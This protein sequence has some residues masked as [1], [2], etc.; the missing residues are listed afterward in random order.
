MTKKSPE[1]PMSLPSFPIERFEVVAKQR[2]LKTEWTLDQADDI[3]ALDPK[4]MEELTQIL[5]KEIQEAM[6]RE[7]LGTLYSIPNYHD[8]GIPVKI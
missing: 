6:N 7:I 3:L 1:D 5:T 4:A 2:T 8:F